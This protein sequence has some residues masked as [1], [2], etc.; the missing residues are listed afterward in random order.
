MGNVHA[1]LG[2]EDGYHLRLASGCVLS[3]VYLRENAQYQN[4]RELVEAQLL[5]LKRK[6]QHVLR[7]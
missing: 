2:G 1:A 6:H 7:S 5:L 4:P 3:K